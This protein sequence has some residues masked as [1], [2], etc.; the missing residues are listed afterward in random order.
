MVAERVKRTRDE[1]WEETA[2]DGK[3]VQRTLGIAHLGGATLDN[4]ENYLIK[5]LFTALGDRA[6]REPGPDMTL[7]HGPRSG[8]L[9]RSRRRDDV[10][11]GSAERRLHRHPGLE[12]GRVPP[13]RLPLGDGG[14]GARARR[15]STSIRASPAPAPWPTCTCRSAPARDIAFLG[16]IV[17]YILEN[18][19]VLPRVRGQLHQRAGDHRARTSATPR[20]STGLFSGW[21]A[22]NGKYDVDIAGSTRASRTVARGGPQG[23]ASREPGARRRDARGRR[24]RRSE[25]RDDDAAAPALRVPDPEAPLLPLHAGDGRARS[26]A[27]RAALFLQ[28]AEALCDNSGRERTSAFCYAVGWTQHSVGVQY[29]RTAAILQLL[30]GNI[31]RPGG[32][33]MALRG[34]ASIQGSTDIP[35]LYNLLPGYLPMPHADARRDA[36]A[37]TSSATSRRPGG[38][39]SCRSTSSRCSRRGSATRP[40]EENDWCF[41]HLPAAHRRPLAHDD[42]RATW[43]TARSR[44]TSSWARTRRSARRTARCSARGCASSTGWWCATSR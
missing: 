3:T 36:R 28:V 13:G 25:H 33:I 27:C 6:G 35:T 34:H 22:E 43:P 2:P 9:V 8:D 38:G 7:L 31:G 1:T 26:A 15:S 41:E 23:A 40:R 37:R 16:G 12:H 42:G 17:R 24:R 32:G 29:I 18:E 39:A 11:A 4:E 20:I 10:P 44:A 14:E 5:K 30:L 19:R 21:D